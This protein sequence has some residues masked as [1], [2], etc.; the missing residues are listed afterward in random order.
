MPA[1]KESTT[2]IGRNIRNRR[3]E[4]NMTQAELSELAG[5][6]QATLSYIELGTN[7]PQFDNLQALAVALQISIDELVKE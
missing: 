2:I 1:Q 5:I 3:N 7:K 4:L 6:T